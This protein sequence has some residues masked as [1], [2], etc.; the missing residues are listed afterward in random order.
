MSSRRWCLISS[1][2]AVALAWCG[3]PSRAFGETSLR[4]GTHLVVV[5]ATQDEVFRSCGSPTTASS[6]LV[7]LRGNKG[8]S[9]RFV[10][11]TWSYDFGPYQFTRNFVFADGLLQSMSLGDYGQ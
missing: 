6:D 2:F 5:G 7:N 10:R 4:C 9:V 3:R 8:P 11:T 1:G